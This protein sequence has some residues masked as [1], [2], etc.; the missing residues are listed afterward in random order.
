MTHDLNSL[1]PAV[2]LPACTDV[3]VNGLAAPGGGYG[4][5]EGAGF[6]FNGLT[7]VRLFGCV[8]KATNNLSGFSKCFAKVI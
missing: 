1:S 8:D 2:C 7:R 5:G 3:A 6:D 4:G